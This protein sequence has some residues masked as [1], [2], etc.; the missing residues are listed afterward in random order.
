MRV[1]LRAA[2]P[3]RRIP[4]RRLHRPCGASVVR[5]D[6]ASNQSH[7]KRTRTSANGGARSRILQ[8]PD[9]QGDFDKM[10][11]E[12]PFL[13]TESQ[14]M[15]MLWTQFF[16]IKEQ[17]ETLLIAGKLL[18]QQSFRFEGKVWCERVLHARTSRPARFNMIKGGGEYIHTSYGRIQRRR[19]CP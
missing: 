14:Q 1:L 2:I 11:G 18:A 9:L 5:R 8:R 10:Q 6:S 12:H 3:Q 13:L 17:G 4:T 7:C 15:S 19:V 16:L